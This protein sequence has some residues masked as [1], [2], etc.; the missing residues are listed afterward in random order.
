MITEKEL[1]KNVRELVDRACRDEMFALQL[2]STAIAAGRSGPD[3]KEYRLLMEHLADSEEDLRR[4]VNPGAVSGAD[5]TTTLT[6][7]TTTTVT[8]TA[9]CTATSLTTTTTVTTD[10]PFA[11]EPNSVPSDSKEKPVKY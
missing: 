4:L 8:T 5:G 9:V 6:T 11:I 2:K 7:T 10:F 1:Q 3:T